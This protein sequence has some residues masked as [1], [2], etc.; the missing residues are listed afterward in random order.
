V[1][2]EAAR[3]QGKF[4]EYHDKLFAN[5]QQLESD[6]LKR[7]AQ[8]L[9]LDLTR[10]DHDRED[11]ALTK[12]VEA[13]LVEAGALM[14]TSTPTVFINGRLVRGAMPLETYSTIIEE[15][16]AKQTASLSPKASSN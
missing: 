16:L 4:W 9:E 5:Q 15:E 8:E 2:A 13:D 11:P 12:K 7:Y 1:A 10:F 3:K 14:I 6:D